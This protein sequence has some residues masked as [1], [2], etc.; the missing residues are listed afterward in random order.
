MVK[1]VY[2]GK[3]YYIQAYIDWENGAHHSFWIN[4]YG[5]TYLRTRDFSLNSKKYVVF[6]SVGTNV[7]NTPRANEYLNDLKVT[8]EYLF[9]GLSRKPDYLTF[10][11][12]IPNFYT[13]DKGIR[14][15][16]FWKR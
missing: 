12:Q 9:S 8:S 6:A 11:R 7:G 1:A 10:M 14:D 5:T 16:A 2:K 3:E 13:L 4:G 15:V